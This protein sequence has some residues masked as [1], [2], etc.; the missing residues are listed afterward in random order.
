MKVSLR[1]ALR[2][3]FAPKSH[4]AVNIISMVAMAGIALATA[5][6]VVVMSVF[7]GFHSLIES[8]LSVLD[9][10]VSVMPLEG[11]TLAGVDSLCSLL[12]KCPSIDR[13]TPL[14]EE[15]ALA[16]AGERQKTVRLRGISPALYDMFTGICPAGEPWQ[17]YHSAAAP[18]VVSVGVAN[19]LE[20]PVGREELLHLYVP[21]RKGRINPANPMSAFRAD[22]VAP[23]AVYMLNQQELDADI[24]Y[25]PIETV[26]NLLQLNDEATEIAV[27][28][29]GKTEKALKDARRVLPE[30]MRVA[31]LQERQSGSFQIVNMEKWLTFLL[32]GFIM[33]IASFNIISSLSLLIIEKEPNA[34]TLRAIGASPSMVRGI[35]RIEGMLITG[36]GAITGLIV[37]SLLSIGQERFGWVKLAGDTD[38]LS[39]T[40]YPVDF[41]IADLL[42]IALLSIAIGL[43]AS[44]ISTR[45]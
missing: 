9:A 10:P 38:M 27:Y 15:R 44:A 8:R 6:L 40:A 41:H 25:A 2:Y 11:K 18:A 3:L 28:P 1:I 22:S 19:R 34:E 26:A 32:L 16:I 7:N 45:K 13:A 33:V 14:I 29:S 35:Y 17:D 24:V 31:A 5:A 42:P 39:V 4:S 37:G 23:S 20:L 43:A 21:R 36:I 30:G 12:E